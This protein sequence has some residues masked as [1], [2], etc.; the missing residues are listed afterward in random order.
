MNKIIAPKLKIGYLFLTIILSFLYGIG[1]FVENYFF[2]NSK[3]ISTIIQES[4]E[5]KEVGAITSKPS[6]EILNLQNNQETTQEK[7]MVIAKTETGNKAIINNEEVEIQPDGKFDGSID[8]IIGENQLLIEVISPENQKTES[9]LII[10]RIII[11]TPIINP[12]SIPSQLPSPTSSPISTPTIK[13]TIVVTTIK[14]IPTTI[15][16][17]SLT[18]LKLSCSVTNTLPKSGQNVD[19]NCIT[20]DQDGSLIPSVNLKITIFWKS[21]NQILDMPTTSNSGNSKISF[22]V[23]N[24]NTGVI[25][26]SITA[27]VEGLKVT[28]N[29]TLNVQ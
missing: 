10:K 20:K 13:P 16:V 19:L 22:V 21:G 7:I 1:L 8:L 26:A 5:V 25:N 4:T 29:F 23:P 18:A 3:Q 27:Q 12:T 24:G 15:P 9:S 11:P 6:L 17:K 14:P 28:S 2:G